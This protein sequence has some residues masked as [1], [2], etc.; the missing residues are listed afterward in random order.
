M[1]NFQDFIQSIEPGRVKE[2]ELA[3]LYTEV[4]RI[5]DLIRIAKEARLRDIPI[6]ILGSGS[7]EKPP[8]SQIKGLAIKNNCRKFDIF[9]L[10]GKI[11]EG[12]GMSNHKLVFAESGAIINQVVR[13]TLEQGLSGLEYQLGLPG[14]V[15]GAI[16]SNARFTPQ[17]AYVNDALEKIRILNDKGEVEE[18][19][20]DYFINQRSS[21]FLPAE[22]IILSATFRLTPESKTVLWEKADKAAEYR[23]KMSANFDE[24]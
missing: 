18:V 13:F 1:S 22:N 5:D 17:N 20:S 4:E 15:G 3:R 7:W 21:G 14:T 2:N 23:N 9:S 10:P 6:Y 24:S 19:A 16:F 8:D 12:Q 11:S